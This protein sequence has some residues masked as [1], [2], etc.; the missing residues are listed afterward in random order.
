MQTIISRIWSLII[1][2]QRYNTSAAVLEYLNVL[3]QATSIFT[4]EF[5][6]TIKL[7]AFLF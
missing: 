2:V 6:L 4:N 7:I 5:H 3:S 1:L